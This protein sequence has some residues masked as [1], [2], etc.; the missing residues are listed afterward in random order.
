MSKLVCLECGH[1]F[2]EE[3][4]VSWRD[5]RGEFWGMPCYEEVSGCPVCKGDYAEAY[6]CD[7]CGEWITGSYV[8]TAND[9]R[10]CEY[11]YS[12]VELGDEN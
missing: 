11:C 3:D 6:I 4:A 1:V 2:D 7:C 5:D 8:K 9:C 10:Y 12:V